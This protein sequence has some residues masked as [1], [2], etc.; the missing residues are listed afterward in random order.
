MTRRLDPALEASRQKVIE[1]L[2]AAFGLPANGKYNI[3]SG[4]A[5][6]LA[7][8]LRD[9]L[10]AASVPMT[11]Q[12]LQTLAANIMD[13]RTHH[14]GLIK[15]LDELGS[16]PGVTPQVLERTEAANLPRSGDRG[17]H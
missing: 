15:N 16:V 6:A 3:N 8:R 13:Y 14:S 9:P 17:R 7:D 4:G 10:A 1:G 12:Q 5:A 2:D 11:D